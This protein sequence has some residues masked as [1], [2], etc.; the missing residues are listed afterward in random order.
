MKRNE[1][2][3]KEERKK[4]KMFLLLFFSLALRIE[5]FRTFS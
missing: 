5:E 2:K 4:E 1:M 3:R